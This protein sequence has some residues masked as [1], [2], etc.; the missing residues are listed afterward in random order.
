MPVSFPPL[1]LHDTPAVYG[2]LSR[3]GHWIGALLV[4]SLLGLGLVADELPRGAWRALL[5]QSHVALGT[6]AAL[7]L[8]LRVLW[9]LVAL[10]TGQSPQPLSAPGWQRRA[11]SGVHLLLLALLLLLPA[12]GLLAIWAGGDAVHI[13]GSLDLPSPLPESRLLHRLCEIVHAV[14]AKLLMGLLL[15]HLLG[16]VRHGRTA[17]QR[18]GGRF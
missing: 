7:P 1:P 12:S 16:V 4:L 15:L 5:H 14:A 3:T 6:L 18:M 10:R 9:R 2:R 8:L 17:W 13:V 11:E